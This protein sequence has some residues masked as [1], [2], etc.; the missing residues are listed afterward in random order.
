MSESPINKGIKKLF[1]SKENTDSQKIYIE[2]P[3]KI[4]L[5]YIPEMLND[6]KEEGL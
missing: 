2:I 5:K 3:N 4:L 6:M 1:G